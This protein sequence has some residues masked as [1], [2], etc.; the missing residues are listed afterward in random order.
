[1]YAQGLA[2]ARKRAVQHNIVR[3]QELAARHDFEAQ[4][5]HVSA[6]DGIGV[7]IVDL[8]GGDGG[9]DSVEALL[10]VGLLLLGAGEEEL[11]VA[12]DGLSRL[13]R[14]EGGRFG[15]GLGV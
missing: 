11:L 4:A 3:L 1:M 2:I 8:E 6:I 12:V 5:E 13:A 15:A 9:G 10:V 14:A 7:G